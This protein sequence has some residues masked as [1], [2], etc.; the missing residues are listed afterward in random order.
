[1]KLV[2]LFQK[3]EVKNQEVYDARQDREESIWSIIM[4]E[5]RESLIHGQHRT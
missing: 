3:T 5:T 4:K 2:I 1:M